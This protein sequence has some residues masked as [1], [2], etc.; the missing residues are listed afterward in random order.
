MTVSVTE[1]AKEL[2]HPLG[3]VYS[4]IYSGKLNATKVDDEWQ[5]DAAAVEDRRKER[6]RKLQE[7]L[8]GIGA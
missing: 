5:I 1:A 4:L 6:V 7:Q 2:N 3:Y 8:E